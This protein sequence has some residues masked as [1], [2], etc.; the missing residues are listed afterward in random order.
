MGDG[1]KQEYENIDFIQVLEY[2][3]GI[4]EVLSFVFELIFNNYASFWFYLTISK[5]FYS[6]K[7]PNGLSKVKHNERKVLWTP[8]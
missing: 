4:H 2:A 8:M 5:L 7:T 6:L 3:G 1:I